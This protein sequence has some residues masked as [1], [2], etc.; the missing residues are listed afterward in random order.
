[1]VA[2]GFGGAG[3]GAAATISGCRLCAMPACRHVQ[4]PLLDPQQLGPVAGQERCCA[5]AWCAGP[6]RHARLH[7]CKHRP[8]L[9]HPPP[10]AR[11]YRSDCTLHEGGR[12]G[13]GD[14]PSS[15]FPTPRL[16]AAPGGHAV[17][18]AA[19]CSTSV[20]LAVQTSGGIEHSGH[21]R[22]SRRRRPACGWLAGRGWR[23]AAASGRAQRSYRLRGG[24][25][26]LRLIWCALSTSTH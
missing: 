23:I 12:A 11:C 7:A 18:I 6:G 15:W 2:A 3:E 4:N 9:R 26:A 25:R 20:K 8:H 13:I 21:V 22:A 19:C 17:V 1:M 16:E 5:A 24:A 14:V 10:S